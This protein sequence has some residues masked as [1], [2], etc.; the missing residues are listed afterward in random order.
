MKISI[1]EWPLPSREL[2]AKAAVFEIR[3]PDTVSKWRDMT[4]RLL[5]DTF[6]PES[7]RPPKIDKIYTLLDFKGV[8][9]YIHGHAPRLQ[10]A[11]VCLHSGLR[12]LLPSE[13]FGGSCNETLLTCHLSSRNLF[14]KLIIQIR[15]SAWHQI[16]TSV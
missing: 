13:A 2:E 12:L 5:V 11:S 15:L 3:V 16:P 7:S 4:Y 9:E 10:L 6:S 1:H 14:H 8:R